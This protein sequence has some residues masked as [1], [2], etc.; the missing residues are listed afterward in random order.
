MMAALCALTAPTASATQLDY[1]FSSSTFQGTTGGTTWG[2]YRTYTNFEA[3]SGVTARATSVATTGAGNTFETAGLFQWTTYGF[4][5]CNQEESA[6]YNS[7]CGLANHQLDNVN[8]TPV[9]GAPSAT[10]NDLDIDFLIIQFDANVWLT[11]LIV[12]PYNP[13]AGYDRDVTIFYGS[14]TYGSTSWILGHNIDWLTSSSGL[15]RMDS[16]DVAGVISDDPRTITLPLVR[17]N[18]IIIA[19]RA[20]GG[21]LAS[22]ATADR[23]KLERLIVN[24][25]APE[26][27]TF[28]MVGL[29]LVGIAAAGRL[30]KK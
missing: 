13:P 16:D 4:G 18:T 22:D 8:H 30:R 7:D 9:S 23:I 15:T 12:N 3:G 29:A 28:A 20:P 11:S 6:T 24:T 19:A 26:P 1:Q 27:A 2:N 17:V 14:T 21:L 10:T 5:I 25:Q